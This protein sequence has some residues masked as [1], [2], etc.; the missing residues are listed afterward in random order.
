MDLIIS[1]HQVLVSNDSAEVQ[2]G[3]EHCCGSLH[4]FSEGS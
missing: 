2:A 1:F 3:K 4:S